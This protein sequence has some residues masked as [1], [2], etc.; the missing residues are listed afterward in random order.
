MV[1]PLTPPRIKWTVSRASGFL[2][3]S[4][5]ASAKARPLGM[6]ARTLLRISG[7]ISSGFSGFSGL[8]SGLSGVSSLGGVTWLA[9]WFFRRTISESLLEIWVK[10]KMLV[11]RPVRVR[12]ARMMMIGRSLFFGL[13][14]ADFMMGEAVGAGVVS[15]GLLGVG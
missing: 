1:Q 8:S 12:M 14:R 10:P 2:A 5:L 9:I 6:L 15:C 7:L 3:L 4:S 11:P 13:L